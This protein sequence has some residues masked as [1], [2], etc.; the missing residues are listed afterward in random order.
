[1]KIPKYVIDIMS[2]AEYNYKYLVSDKNYAAGYT[3]RIYKETPYTKVA[4]LKAEI[5]RLVKWAN[6]NGGEGTAYILGLPNKTHYYDQSAIV[7]IF[8]PVM[9]QIEK[10][11]DS[12]RV[13]RAVLS[14]SR[15][16]IADKCSMLEFS[17]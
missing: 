16:P 14:A 7:T 4:A 2:R 15:K 3:L 13:S 6:K 5:E 17:R 8:D 10:Y 11:I 9:Q 12:P 1:M